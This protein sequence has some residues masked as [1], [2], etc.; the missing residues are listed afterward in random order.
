MAAADKAWEIVGWYQARWV[1]EQL[2]R[3]IKSQG[4]QLA[5]ADRLVKLAT[6]AIKAACV[7]IQLVQE[8][9]GKHQLPASTVFSGLEIEMLVPTLERKTERQKN[10]TRLAASPGKLGRCPSWR[11]EL[12]L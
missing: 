7:D 3:V 6:A 1:I 12:L 9:D 11:L 2:F 8:R 10:R 4:L 5:S